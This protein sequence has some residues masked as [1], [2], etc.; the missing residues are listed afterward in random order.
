MTVVNKD[1]KL[2]PASLTE[3][4]R[5]KAAIFMMALR[6]EYIEGPHRITK[7]GMGWLRPPQWRLVNDLKIKF[8]KRWRNDFIDFFEHVE[9]NKTK[10]WFAT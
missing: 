9:N 8:S 3:R 2:I 6:C 5:R 4:Q 1:G 7:K 10:E